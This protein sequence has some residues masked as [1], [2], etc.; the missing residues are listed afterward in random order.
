MLWRQA[1]SRDK[2]SDLSYYLKWSDD[3][4]KTPIVVV[5]KIH[6]VNYDYKKRVKIIKIKSNEQN[7]NY[8]VCKNLSNIILKKSAV[9]KDIA[10][11]APK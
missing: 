5:K 9:T 11:L 4:S 1:D 2:L 3:L 10:N 6:H 7:L 8:L